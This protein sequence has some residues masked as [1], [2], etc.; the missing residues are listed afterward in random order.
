MSR[1]RS[2]IRGQA[3]VEYLL[4]CLVVL[5]LLAADA[6]SGESTLSLVIRSVRE[7]FARFAAALS[8][9]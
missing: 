9:A 6:A 5:A 3:S 7:G 2:A 1:A 8:I 4:G